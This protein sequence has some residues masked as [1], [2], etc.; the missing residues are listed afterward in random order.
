MDTPTTTQLHSRAQREKE[1]IWERKINSTT[2]NKNKTRDEENNK[3]L[4]AHRVYSLPYVSS[5]LLYSSACRRP[6]VSCE[7][8]VDAR[9]TAVR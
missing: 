6:M 8:A 4:F 9:V 2:Q 1:A 5:M 3:K 7:A